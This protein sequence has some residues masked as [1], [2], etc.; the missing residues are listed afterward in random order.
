MYIVEVVFFLS[1]YRLYC[2]F[3]VLIRKWALSNNHG[4]SEAFHSYFTLEAFQLV[5]T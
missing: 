2:G 4:E 3:Q 5:W 1:D